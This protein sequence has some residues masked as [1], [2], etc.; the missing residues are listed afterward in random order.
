MG[1]EPMQAA[2]DFLLQTP[3]YEQ[4]A[5][6]LLSALPQPTFADLDDG[7]ALLIIAPM[8]MSLVQG[9]SLLAAPDLC[10]L[11][12]AHVMVYDTKTASPFCDTWILNKNHQDPTTES[13]MHR[14]FGLKM[15]D[16]TFQRI[17]P[18]SSRQ[19]TDITSIRGASVVDRHI[20][21]E[22]KTTILCVNSTMMSV[23]ME[24]PFALEQIGGLDAKCP[25]P[26]PGLNVLGAGG[27]TFD[28]EA[29]MYGKVS[30]EPI[31]PKP[32]ADCGNRIEFE[33]KMIPENEV[34]GYCP[35]LR[36][37]GKTK[38]MQMQP[39]FLLTLQEGPATCQVLQDTSPELYADERIAMQGSNTSN[40]YTPRLRL[41]VD[42]GAGVRRA[43]YSKTTTRVSKGRV[44]YNHADYLKIGLKPPTQRCPRNPSEETKHRIKTAARKLQD[45]YGGSADDQYYMLFSVQCADDR[46]PAGILSWIETNPFS[47]RGSY[48]CLSKPEQDARMEWE[49]SNRPNAPWWQTQ[50]GSVAPVAIPKSI[51][52]LD[53]ELLLMLG[54]SWQNT[55][56]PV[57]HQCD[58]VENAPFKKTKTASTT[59]LHNDSFLLTTVS[60]VPETDVKLKSSMREVNAM[61]SEVSVYQNPTLNGFRERITSARIWW[62]T[63]FEDNGMP[64]FVHEQPHDE[65]LHNVPL[66]QLAVIIADAVK[67]GKL[68]VVVLNTSST[69]ELGTA[70]SQT[71][72]VPLVVCWDGHVEDRAA[73]MF[74]TTLAASFKSGKDPI[75]AF[76][77][78]KSKVESS[79]NAKGQ[80]FILQKIDDAVKATE[81]HARELIVPVG[82]PMMLQPT[83]T[84]MG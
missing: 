84:N 83:T 33:G 46:S 12:K 22:T 41:Q 48:N 77:R 68:E 64:L 71:A 34:F 28:V 13:M 8:N 32:I 62:Y 44:V 37:R 30:S 24:E 7:E 60:E 53:A 50:G 21:T 70:L 66:K 40:I 72:N 49:R 51:P 4:F 55:T 59:S 57:K 1:G 54:T 9:V 36:L 31:R 79:T 15:A 80:R 17:L 38:E 35:D 18:A 69:L 58:P 76:E 67:C 39:S 23:A 74:G 61:R 65:Y 73:Y 3:D 19:L 63:G 2:L 52:L 27:G 81:V 14:I 5:K 42:S 82:L 47:L 56:L 75:E 11:A 29:R 6:I 43:L 78:A 26:P 20:I 10:R 16:G 45:G 25:V